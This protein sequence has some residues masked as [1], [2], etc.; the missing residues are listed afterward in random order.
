MKKKQKTTTEPMALDGALFERIQPH[1]G[2]TFAEPNYF[3]LGDGYMRCLHVYA[4]PSS[5]PEF[6]LSRVF[7]V[8]S[9][10]CSI[11]VSTKDMAEVKKN[12]NKSITEENARAVTSK[13]YVDLYDA[14]R[15]RFE[16]EQLLDEVSRMGEVIKVCDFRI[17]VRAR[18]LSDLEERCAEI[19]KNLDADSFRATVL[20]NEQKTEWQSLFEP[21][22]ITHQKPLTLKG[23]SLTT[24]QLASGDPFNHSELLDEQ[25][26][27]LG[28]SNTGGAVVFDEFT[29]TNKRKHY[30]AVVCGDMGS[31]KSTLLKKRFK[32]HASIGNFIRTFDVAGEFHDLTLEFGG[33]VIRCNGSEG[34]LN[35][36]EILQAGE[37]DYTSYSIHISKMQAFF[38]CIIPSM[39][40]HLLQTLANELR[41]L[42]EY[43]N[44]VPDDDNPITGL[45]PM[46]YPTLSDFK[47]F[48][49]QSIRDIQARD[50]SAST[51][52][53]TAL[54]VEQAKSLDTILGAVR[55][56]CDNYGNL[57]DGHTTFADISHEKIVTFDISAIR[58]LG[59]VFTAQMQ[60]LVALCW[61]NAMTNGIPQKAA[62]ESGTPIEDIIKFLIIIDESHNW[63]NTRMPLI[64]DLIIRY[65]REARKYFAGIVLASQ[66]VR[67]F[68]PEANADSMDKIRTI[69]ELAQ[70]KFM[71]KQDSAAKEH[72]RK[73]FGDGLT[74]AQVERIPFLER[75]DTILSIAGDRSL[76]MKVWLSRDY[77]EPLFRGG[78]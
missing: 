35:P 70:Y 37:D 73:I 33:R 47:L 42:Y 6:W 30:N 65:M 63:V 2:I 64:L 8:S 49:E 46:E 24:E 19:L 38:R 52:V 18:T 11:D 21:S 78:R 20:L 75:G 72:I 14:D 23:L 28:F 25:G 50:E 66:S 5:L 29:S 54:N 77:E 22:H 34:M 74:Y 3:T 67:D 60:I 68:M 58:D 4:L 48:L 36:L 56:L 59:N 62:W 10:I 45:D 51:D 13:S 12:I 16:L 53:E 55:N 9:A 1:G 44:L 61:D 76:E 32:H 41:G 57:F 71:L 27:L 7:S 69:F 40:D 17:F 26:T 15:R 39:D 31:G 43:H